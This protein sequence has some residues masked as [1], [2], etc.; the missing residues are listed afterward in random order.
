[1]RVRSGR[2]NELAHL[3]KLRSFLCRVALCFDPQVFDADQSLCFQPRVVEGLL[4]AWGSRHVSVAVAT[5]TVLDGGDEIDPEGHQ[6]LDLRAR[7]TPLFP[8]AHA[9]TPSNPFLQFGDRPVILADAV[10]RGPPSKVLPKL[11]QPVLH[12]DSPTASCEFFDLVLEVGEGLLS[13]EYFAAYDREPEEAALTHRCYLAF[14]RVDLEFEGAFQIPRD[15]THH[16]LGSASAFV[17]NDHVIG[18]AR[19]AVTPSLQFLVELVQ[20]DIGQ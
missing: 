6:I 18:V 20:Q 15:G 19:K 10:I 12:G 16:P 4:Q 14:G 8:V 17:K 2:F 1:M 3:P 11:V 9:D 5:D 7:P 13:P